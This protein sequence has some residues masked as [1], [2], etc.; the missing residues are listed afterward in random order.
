M[1]NRWLNKNYLKVSKFNVKP[2][3]IFIISNTIRNNYSE[4]S[5]EKKIS[6]KNLKPIEK[7]LKMESIGYKAVM[8]S[9]KGNFFI[10]GLKFK[11]NLKELNLLLTLVQVLLQCWLKLFTL[12]S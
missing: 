2:N 11:L 10:L 9:L 3:K 12:Y 8:A 4:N 5:E 6:Q 1:L 7:E